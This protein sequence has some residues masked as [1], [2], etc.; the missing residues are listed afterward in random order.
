MTDDTPTHIGVIE[1]TGVV[2]TPEGDKILLETDQ[3]RF[4]VTITDQQVA[5]AL[6]MTAEQY[7]RSVVRGDTDE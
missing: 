3:G 1:T 4:L 6:E 2:D 7:R 5:T